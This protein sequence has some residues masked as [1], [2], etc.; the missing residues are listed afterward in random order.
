MKK[1]PINIK[2]HLFNELKKH[3]PFWS[4][5]YIK[6][7]QIDDDVLIEKVLLLLDLKDIEKLFLILPYKKIKEVWINNILIQDPYYH[8]LNIL[9]ASLYFNIKNPG[10]YIERAV[11]VQRKSLSA[12]ERS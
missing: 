11:K 3:K 12:H 10:Q 4:Y 6:P 9:L 2:K 5:E 1:D 7:D 8:S